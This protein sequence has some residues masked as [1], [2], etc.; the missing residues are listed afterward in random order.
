M[1]DDVIPARR[2]WIVRNATTIVATVAV[3]LYALF[4]QWAWGWAKVLA[5]W[6]DVGVV[7]VLAAIL[8][9][10]L[11]YVLRTWRIHDYFPQETRGQFP[12]LLRLVQVH[13][14][15]NVMLPFRTGE[16]SFPVLMKREFGL[17][18]ARGTSAL[19][20]MRLLDLHALLAAAGIGLALERQASWAWGVWVCFVGLPALGFAI[21]KQAFR[22][23]HR[24]APPR[25]SSVLEELEAG[26][27][28]DAAAFLRAWL[29]TLVNWLVKVVV[30]AWVIL[31]LDNLPVSAAFGGALG[32][33]LSSVLPVHAPG[34][35]GTYPA[36]ITAGALAFGAARDSAALTSL[37]Q[38]AVN[39][40]LMIIVTSVIGTVVSMLVAMS[41]PGKA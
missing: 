2:S 33:E 40:H 35:A 17:A 21:R 8:L 32:G 36:G 10:L 34:G 13:N 31:L 38:A 23:T 37:G 12:R 7:Q 27:P 9:L 16:V 6:Q 19:L 22:F 11:T 18:M 24:F 3:G 41:R 4:V 5:L 26:L 39:A 29:V 1:T 20:V 15:L 28:K 25:L 14:L 30:L